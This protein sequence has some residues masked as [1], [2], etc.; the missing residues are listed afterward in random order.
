MKQIAQSLL[1][2]Q[3]KIRNAQK[4]AK[5]PHFRSDYATLESVIGAVKEI[6]NEQGILIVQGTGS[7]E[8]GQYVN[9]TLIHAESGESMSSKTYLI[10]DKST[11][12]GLGSAI[13]YA[14]RYGVAA[15][16]FIGQSDDDANEASKKPQ[17]VTPSNYRIELTG[18]HFGKL[19]QDV[20]PKDLEAYIIHLE[21]KS[22]ETKLPL[23]GKGKLFVEMATAFLN[24]GE[25]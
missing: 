6:A 17:Q 11:M 23:I 10:L 14:R 2:A 22:K 13:T 8:L 9:T 21:K 18:A 15:M 1:E 20:P 16:F 19:L 4:D 24:Q 5:N 3:K 12:Q 25:D 7:D